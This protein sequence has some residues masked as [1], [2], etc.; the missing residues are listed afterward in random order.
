MLGGGQRR[1]SI[2]ESLVPWDGSQVV[3]L[4][5]ASP[6]LNSAADTAFVL[7]E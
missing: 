1:T 7:R 2:V 5:G 4:G 6:S 3:R